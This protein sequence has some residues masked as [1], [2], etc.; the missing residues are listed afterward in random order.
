MDTTDQRKRIESVFRE[1]GSLKDFNSP[2]N[3]KNKLQLSAPKFIT[4]KNNHCDATLST[5][6]SLGK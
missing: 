3:V 6:K 5:I 2:L 1:K 4:D